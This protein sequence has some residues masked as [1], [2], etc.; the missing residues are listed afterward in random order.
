ML[1][2]ADKER[3]SRALDD[4]IDETVN[5]PFPAVFQVETAKYI[6]AGFLMTSSPMTLADALAALDRMGSSARLIAGELQ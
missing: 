2:D 3:L 1:T 6:Q 4:D 5:Q